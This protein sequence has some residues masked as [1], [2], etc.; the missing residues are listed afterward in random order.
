MIIENTSLQTSPLTWYLALGLLAGL[1]LSAGLIVLREYL[2]Q[3]IKDP[4][5]VNRLLGVPLLGSVPRLR[6]LDIYNDLEVG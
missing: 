2:D 6:D 5:E 3:A 1:A 4:Q